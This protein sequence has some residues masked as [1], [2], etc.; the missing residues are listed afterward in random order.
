MV[1]T[2][3]G[4]IKFSPICLETDNKDRFWFL[5]KMAANCA[6]SGAGPTQGT[7]WTEKTQAGSLPSRGSQPNEERHISRCLLQ[8]SSHWGLG[9]TSSALVIREGF[10]GEAGAELNPRAVRPALALSGKAF[11]EQLVTQE[12]FLVSWQLPWGHRDEQW[13]GGR[14]TRP[15]SSASPQRQGYGMNSDI[16]KSVC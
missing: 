4:T 1:F 7:R 9:S 16:P 2:P 11:S 5:E 8:P 15:L 3:P 10:Q 13:Q 6:V 14:V 12:Y